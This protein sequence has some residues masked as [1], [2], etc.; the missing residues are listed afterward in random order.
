MEKAQEGVCAICK[1]KPSV[2]RLDVDHNH[3]TGKVRGLLCNQCNSSLGMMGESVERLQV[4]IAY[5]QNKG[6]AKS[7]AVVTGP[8]QS[9]EDEQERWKTLIEE[10]RCV[11]DR[12]RIDKLEEERRWLLSQ[13]EAL[14]KT[15]ECLET[16]VPVGLLP[17][18]SRALIKALI[19]E[20][21][22]NRR[23]ESR[24]RG[25]AWCDKLLKEVEENEARTR[26]RTSQP[27][28]ELA[29]A[30]TD[31]EPELEQQQTESPAGAECWEGSSGPLEPRPPDLESRSAHTSRAGPG[32]SGG[33]R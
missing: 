3:K 16:P 21:K 14:K 17:D 19:R 5:L 10:R 27:P 30:S 1:R 2:R 26:L 33:S 20:V 22:S 6:A 29:P 31:S 12:E 18:M 24:E 23:T 9:S 7:Q 8:A 15:V 13:N 32:P 28:E 11:R 25:L 4:A